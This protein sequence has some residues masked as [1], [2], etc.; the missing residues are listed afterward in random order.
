MALLCSA[1][2]SSVKGRKKRRRPRLEGD[3]LRDELMSRERQEENA[4]LEVNTQFY[5][6]RAYKVCFRIYIYI[7]KALC[8]SDKFASRTTKA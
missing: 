8:E 4:V 6:A 7:Y 2:E 5:R 3:K 1:T